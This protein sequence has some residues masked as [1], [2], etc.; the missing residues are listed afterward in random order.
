MRITIKQR[1]GFAG[2]EVVLA[3]LDT[4]T[5]DAATR[6]SIEQQVRSAA[7][8]APGERPVGSDLMEYE[9]SLED[10][11]AVTR[12]TW[13][14]DGGAGAQPVKDLLARLS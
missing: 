14:E 7:A 8:A 4:A 11:G 2:G 10:G 13:V 12:R 3:N 1:G 6:A 5:L 9:M